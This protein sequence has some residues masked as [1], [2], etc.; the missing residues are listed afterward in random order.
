MTE[1]NDAGLPAALQAGPTS[2]SSSESSKAQLVLQ[3]AVSMLPPEEERNSHDLQC[4]MPFA[5]SRQRYLLSP[6]VCAPV[7]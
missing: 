2:A 6:S 1:A 4:R 5:L 3:A 7:K